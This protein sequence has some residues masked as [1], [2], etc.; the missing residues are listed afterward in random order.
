MK[1]N[2]T[3]LFKSIIVSVLIGLLLV[4]LAPASA[5]KPDAPSTTS[6]V[7]PIDTEI[8]ETDPTDNSYI[9]E[10]QSSGSGNEIPIVSSL[11]Q[12]TETEFPNDITQGTFEDKVE[13]S[14]GILELNYG[15]SISVT[16]VGN[17]RTV[18]A[19]A[20]IYLDLT[21]SFEDMIVQLAELL[22]HDIDQDI[23]AI[24]VTL[25]EQSSNA[26]DEILSSLV[27][28][29][30]KNKN[31]SWF[32]ELLVSINADI[33][34]TYTRGTFTAEISKISLWGQFKL[35]VTIPTDKLLAFLI[36]LASGG[37][38][39]FL[40]PYVDKLSDFLTPI[41]I[42]FSFS[43]TYYP[44]TFCVELAVTNFAFE[45]GI[46]IKIGLGSLL[47]ANINFI[48][49]FDKL[50]IKY[51]FGIPTGIELPSSSVFYISLDGNIL[52][53]KFNYK[54]PLRWG[55][56][57]AESDN[58]AFMKLSA[59]LD[60]EDKP[61]SWIPAGEPVKISAFIYHD[62]VSTPEK[63]DPT[64]Q[65]DIKFKLL[66]PR[67]DK[68]H[69]KT[70]YTN[71]AGEASYTFYATRDGSDGPYSIQI[72][73]GLILIA[74]RTLFIKKFISKKIDNSDLHPI[75][76]VLVSASG[77]AELG[78]SQTLDLTINFKNIGDQNSG[79]GSGTHV[80]LQNA[81]IVAVKPNQFRNYL[82]LGKA[83]TSTSVSDIY[84]QSE[85][86]WSSSTSTYN[87]MEIYDELTV[88]E[89]RSVTI[90]IKATDNN[91]KLFY[92]SWLGD[93]DNFI[94]NDIAKIYQN[95]YTRDN[96]RRLLEEQV[97]SNYMTLPRIQYIE[98]TS[99]QPSLAPT[100]L[101][102]PS[103]STTG[104][105]SI[106][107]NAVG[108]SVD[109]YIIREFSDSSLRNI[110]ASWS[111]TSTS[112]SL[113][114]R[115]VVGSLV[116]RYYV[117]Y[118]IDINGQTSPY[119]NIKRVSINIPDIGE[120]MLKVAP[121][122]YGTGEKEVDERD[123]TVRWVNAQFCV[124]CA[125]WFGDYKVFYT[126]PNGETITS[127][128][129]DL[130][131]PVSN[132][133]DGRHTFVVVALEDGIEISERSEPVVYVVSIP[134]PPSN[135]IVMGNP[136]FGI[137]SEIY[138]SVPDVYRQG[139]ST[140]IT[141]MT[142]AKYYIYNTRTD[143]MI[144]SGDLVYVYLKETW[145]TFQFWSAMDPLPFTFP[146][147]SYYV[148]VYFNDGFAS[149]MSPKPT[150]FE[151]FE[152]VGPTGDGGSMYISSPR[153]YVDID[154]DGVLDHIYIYRDMLQI[155]S[156]EYGLLPGWPVNI[157]YNDRYSDYWDANVHVH[158]VTGDGEP[159]IL[160]T[161]QSYDAAWKHIVRIYDLLGNEASYSPFI[162]EITNSSPNQITNL[163]FADLDN[164]DID[165]MIFHHGKN[166]RISFYAL[167][168][169][170]GSDVSGFPKH[171]L[172][173]TTPAN[174]GG[175]TLM[176]DI[177][178]DGQ[179]EII[180]YNVDGQVIALSLSGTVE[181]I[182]PVVP[183]FGPS[184]EPYIAD[185]CG[186]SA[187]D[188]I[189]GGS[190]YLYN[191]NGDDYT[192][193]GLIV[194]EAKSGWI[195]N[196]KKMEAPDT[197]LYVAA[198]GNF[199]SDSKHE[200]IL[201][202]NIQHMYL[203]EYASFDYWDF[204]V[205]DVGTSSTIS[206]TG[207]YL[208]SKVG[209]GNMMPFDFDGDGI[210]EIIASGMGVNVINHL[211]QI[212][213]PG[214]F[215]ATMLSSR[216]IPT[217]I[218]GDGLIEFI[219][220]NILESDLPFTQTGVS[221]HPQ[222]QYWDTQSDLFKPSIYWR[223][224]D[225]F[226]GLLPVN[227]Y[228]DDNYGTISEVELIVDGQLYYRD[229][230]PNYEKY[231]NMNLDLGEGAHEIRVIATDANGNQRIVERT[232]T[233]DRQGPEVVST[234][235]PLSPVIHTTFDSAISLLL[236]VSDDSGLESN[237]T[238]YLDGE[239]GFTQLVNGQINLNFNLPA[240]MY[241]LLIQVKDLMGNPLNLL[242]VFEIVDGITDPSNFQVQGTDGSI[243]LTW[244]VPQSTGE[245]SMAYFLIYRSTDGQ[246][247]GDYIAN[248]SRYY[249]V[250]MEVTP[251]IS[252]YYKVVAVNDLEETSP[253]DLIIPGI[254][255]EISAP[256]PDTPTGLLG[257]GQNAKN[258]L[259]WNAV[260]NADY[261]RIYRSH[262]GSFVSWG[263]STNP[264]F[265][266]IDLLNGD[267]YRYFVSSINEIGESAPSETIEVIP[268]ADGIVPAAPVIEGISYEQRAK[269]IWTPP[270]AGQSPIIKYEI[271]RGDSATT[272]TEYLGSTTLLQF[273]D[274]DVNIG[275]DYFYA[276][277]AIN[278]EGS[279]TLSNAVQIIIEE[280]IVSEPTIS[281][282]PSMLPIS[283]LTVLFTLLAVPK[284][285]RKSKGM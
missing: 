61:I 43:L 254:A 162:T 135:V 274:G 205:H 75:P 100:V 190:Y 220:A 201:A 112:I 64:G 133:A 208:M 182:S 236:V 244:D 180:G 107:W 57:T 139:S 218:D 144:H 251:G 166:N 160:I 126:K 207:R 83:T 259:S 253:G 12:L 77:I 102:G 276:V 284:L 27:A 164:D 264:E 32:K 171:D 118:A 59:G 232:V 23:E 156:L 231:I 176:M 250:D 247:F 103:S 80:Y 211:G 50:K 152:N 194:L 113:N 40:A 19:S 267:S 6:P 210:D 266:D 68:I 154:A 239:V 270:F 78:S 131:Y 228:L 212:I 92:R 132:A 283:W 249:F 216:M 10:P 20:G 82:V 129:R 47:T 41:K 11:I 243:L 285:R 179:L 257:T 108:Y 125:G 31:A 209:T 203:S 155:K 49:K 261:Y 111:T 9:I 26:A 255:S 96:D 246:T 189:L 175:R 86:T 29:L 199:D 143:Q 148:R 121:D 256:R 14:L 74:E 39:A 217:D 136:V 1:I 206:S 258:E 168:G 124:G 150:H 233:I 16:Q 63:Y 238:F 38:L 146:D 196:P 174:S 140:F 94:W 169:E 87:L 273:I 119:S 142:E 188:L 98:E 223:N 268:S 42:A 181:G 225:L 116:Y 159:E 17:T 18:K 89:T 79:A 229:T 240:G 22:I 279:S 25:A 170:D 172:G 278:A 275:D 56:P 277:R 88:G 272:I 73:D 115:G 163:V 60:P 109:K 202:R 235:L 128:V 260:S 7:T 97:L 191:P 93:A 167:N 69:L 127:V 237:V 222:I 28:Y 252:Y 219:G 52:I 46:G 45:I 242:Y 33:E 65:W 230:T 62:D 85:T 153:K 95:Y 215:T 147:G 269:I 44:S 48:S 122:L 21:L 71:S 248:T 76:E 36:S 72:Y 104:D 101:S 66:T 265:V 5:I 137:G 4:S 186:S 263:I 158:D 198:V 134:P 185:V 149:G 187:P 141:S 30:V 106:N 8:K 173:V 200:I 226:D 177:D 204:T 67:G 105:F 99:T 3:H 53:E 245:G 224:E 70:D 2:Q 221:N 54:I 151:G 13:I 138:I 281:E 195:T 15:M 123:F 213:Y 51:Y 262:M 178:E 184:G 183:N 165:E 130:E 84:V 161:Y 81:V 37:S 282:E 91:P 227:V 234:N 114:D 241:Q 271:Y 192:A 214:V 90:T 280:I 120:Y 117:V 35:D 34:F 55:W 110:V 24:I 193:H 157:K 58:K 145:G 197:S